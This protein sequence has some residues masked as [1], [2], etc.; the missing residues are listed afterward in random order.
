MDDDGLTDDELTLDA[1]DCDDE[2]LIDEGLLLDDGL[3]LELLG[4]GEE[5]D[6]EGTEFEEEE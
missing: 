6:D 5:L 3:M 1:D 4:D 2:G